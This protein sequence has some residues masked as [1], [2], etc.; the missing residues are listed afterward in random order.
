[1]PAELPKLLFL[2]D[3]FVQPGLSLFKQL[4]SE[5]DD[6]ACLLCAQQDYRDLLPEESNIKVLDGLR[7]EKAQ[8]NVQSI[9]SLPLEQLYTLISSIHPSVLLV[10]SLNALELLF[11][12]Q[13]LYKLFKKLMHNSA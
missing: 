11:S 5:A 12:A 2:S 10:D 4:L 13:D 7:S 3:S 8:A 6:Q 9:L 1:M